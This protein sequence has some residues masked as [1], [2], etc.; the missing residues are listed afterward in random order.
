MSSMLVYALI[1]IS[2]RLLNGGISHGVVPHQLTFSSW[3]SI[4][5]RISA[6]LSLRAV[7][8]TLSLS[9]Y[10]PGPWVGLSIVNSSTGFLGAN[11]RVARSMRASS[12]S[13][14][15]GLELDVPP[16]PPTLAGWGARAG[17]A[18]R[19]VGGIAGAGAWTGGLAAA[20]FFDFDLDFFPIVV[21][22]M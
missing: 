20:F 12:R 9:G 6:C 19:L 21:V 7:S 17:G 11:C 18:G 8:S 14:C 16:A 10:Q 13:F 22:G 4:W 15:V 2:K 3:T 5:D 1:M